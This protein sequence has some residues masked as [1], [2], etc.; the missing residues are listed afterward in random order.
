MPLFDYFCTKCG[1]IKRDVLI[2]GSMH[3]PCHCDYEMSKLPSAPSFTIGGYSYKN[4]Y[5]KEGGNA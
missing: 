1:L 5:S 3:P 2:Q 4:G